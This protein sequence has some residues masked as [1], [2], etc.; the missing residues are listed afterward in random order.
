[1]VV[2]WEAEEGGR[3][4]MGRKA[5]EIRATVIRFLLVDGG[6]HTTGGE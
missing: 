6:T 4:E 3:A 5:R 1:V 2:V